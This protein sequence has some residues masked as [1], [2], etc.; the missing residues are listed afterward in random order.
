MSL[1]TRLAVAFALVAGVVAALV[2]VLSYHAAADRISQEVDQTLQA[3][4]TSLASGQTAVLSA[5][6]AI[7]A[8]ER[9][10]G[11]DGGP[12]GEGQPVVAQSVAADGSVTHLGGRAVTLPVADA[13]RALATAGAG[14]TR[15]TE[16]YLG[17]T[18]F[19]VLTTA[20]GDG[21]G[22]LQVG[23][24]IDASDFVLQ[25]MAI[26]IAILSAVVLVAAAVAGWV[27][28]R[29]ITWR[30]VRLTEVAEEV[31]AAGLVE[32][33]VPVLGRDEVGRLSTSF[34]TMLRR[35][36]ESRAS[37][38]RLVQDAAHELRTPLTSLRTNA[39]VLRR[40]AELSPA[41]QARLVED[42]EGET[43]ELSHLVDELVELAL[44]R[45]GAGAG[46]DEPD[47]E[48]A[49]SVVVARAAERTRRRSG[50]TI[51]VHADAT[52]VRGRD[53]ALERAAG[54][55]LENAAKFD[56]N[57]SAPIEIS[58]RRGTVTVA[59]RGPGL[60]ADSARVFDRFYRA[61]TARGL[62]GSGLGL[63]IVRDV[64]EDHDGTVFAHDRPGGGAVIG[65]T[66]GSGRLLPDSEQGHDGDSP[67][68]SSVRGVP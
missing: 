39:S 66:V 2:G 14:L 42:V 17:R 9:D 59:D 22:A 21:R 28:A 47:E 41:S 54:N 23:A 6:V 40:F 52:V 44:A 51:A 37:Q 68:P 57:G 60:G 5:P 36:A 16:L 64:A 15:T 27:L 25:G 48:V 29:R 31:S 24:D 32:H 13:D 55:L 33:E 7:G 34:N 63:A 49:L 50:R 35:L 11:G 10:G 61:D 19:R 56:R 3:V 53:Q 1:A 18:H 12:R 8:G 30:L 58:V 26:E 62:P 20:L 65:F 4:T 43:R 38:E 45:H 46:D 67:P